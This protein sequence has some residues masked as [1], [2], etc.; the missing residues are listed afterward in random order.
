MLP[1]HCG[2]LTCWHIPLR[3]PAL[4][5]ASPHRSVITGWPVERLGPAVLRGG[6]SH[7]IE[8]PPNHYLPHSY[9]LMA[10]GAA[11]CLSACSPATATSQ[12]TP[13]VT[14]DP[15]T[16]LRHRPLHLPQV[17]LGAP[18][19]RAVGRQV[20]PTY[21]IAIG[22]GPAYAVG[23]GTEGVLMYGGPHNFGGG[24]YGGDKVLWIVSSAY[25]DLVL[26]RGQQVDGSLD[27]RF[28]TGGDPP[29][30]LSFTAGGGHPGGVD[31]GDL[32]D[33]S[34]HTWLL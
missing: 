19:P 13:I 24:E 7:V 8:A 16:V 14:A 21:G 6:L 1:G 23:L 3:A 29:Q 12:P 4:K 2:D 27:V 28:D 22:D 25:R 9:V 33:P 5:N 20:V 30:E 17:A 32:V 11:L 31:R 10:V 15:L 26:I 18:C 34:Q